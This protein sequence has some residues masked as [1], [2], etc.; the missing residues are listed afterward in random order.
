MS[1]TNM[2]LSTALRKGWLPT[3]IGSGT[4][5]SGHAR[6]RLRTLLDEE[7]GRQ[8]DASPHRFLGP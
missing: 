6:T 7:S 8:R 3:V 5:P 4:Q 2:I 1:C